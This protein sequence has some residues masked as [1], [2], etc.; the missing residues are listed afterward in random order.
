[1]PESLFRSRTEGGLG[2]KYAW[3]M[4]SNLIPHLEEHL[5]I[6]LRKS[7]KWK[8]YRDN[9]GAA[10]LLEHSTAPFCAYQ[11]DLVRQDDDG[12]DTVCRLPKLARIQLSEYADKLIKSKGEQ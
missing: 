1:M 4:Q 9:I 10:L 7:G 12:M 3:H 2:D 11:V 6:L 5:K 8:N